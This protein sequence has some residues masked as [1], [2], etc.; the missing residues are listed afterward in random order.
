MSGATAI[1]LAT[2]VVGAWSQ[3]LCPADDNCKNNRACELGCVRPPSPAL[4]WPILRLP[5]CHNTHRSLEA[6]DAVMLRVIEYAGCSPACIGQCDC[7]CN[8]SGVVWE[9]LTSDP[10][11][12]CTAPV[13]SDPGVVRMMSYPASEFSCDAVLAIAL[14]PIYQLCAKTGSICRNGACTAEDCIRSVDN[15]CLQQK[16]VGETPSYV[17]SA[18]AGTTTIL[19]MWAWTAMAVAED[20]DALENDTRHY[21]PVPTAPPPAY[22]PVASTMFARRKPQSVDVI[23]AM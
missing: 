15:A 14:V 18:L 4:V 9:A 19:F 12:Y 5:F 13:C 2:I 10:V 1:L 7:V 23:E 17:I 6:F 20:V 3:T 16:G 11:P 8:Q 21:T 22:R